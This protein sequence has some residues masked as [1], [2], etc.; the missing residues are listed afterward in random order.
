MAVGVSASNDTVFQLLLRHTRTF[1]LNGLCPFDN[2]TTLLS[3][4][5][6]KVGVPV[7][8]MFLIFQVWCG[9]FGCVPSCL[10]LVAPI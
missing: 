8:A 2:M 1:T 7:S 5:E 6:F 9:V 10:N 4:A 3:A